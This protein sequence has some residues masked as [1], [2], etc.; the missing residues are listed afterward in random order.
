VLTAVPL[1]LAVT[2]PV[3]WGGGFSPPAQSLFVLLAGGAVLAAARSD[4]LAAGAAARSPLALVL[5]AL[6]GLSAASAAW[7]IASPGVALR[8]GLVVAGYAGIVIAGR[9]TAS[10]LGATSIAVAVAAIAATEAVLG[11]AAVATHALP[12]AE[13]LGRVWRPGG[14]FEY[15][16]ALALLQVG[17]LSVLA[18]AIRRSSAVAAGVAAG[19]TTLAG[20]VLALSG[21]RLA[22]ALAAIV[23]VGLAWDRPG[24]PG[25]RAAA[26]AVAILAT[27]G[28]ILASVLLGGAVGPRSPAPGVSGLAAFAAVVL[29]GALT[30]PPARDA[31]R[32]RSHAPLAVTLGCAAAVLAAVALVGDYRPIDLGHG[33]RRAVG[34]PAPREQ[35]DLVHER[36]HEWL[37]AIQTWIDRPVLGAG[38]GAYYPA[39]LPHQRVARSL[40]AH[41]LPLELAA[42]LGIAG[43]LLGIGLYGVCARALWR[44]R[45]DADWWLLAPLVVAFLVSNM[46]DWTWHLSGLTALW[47]AAAGGLI[48]CSPIRA[49]GA[50]TRGRC[51]G[52]GSQPP[53]P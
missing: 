9:A 13:R 29:A 22:L 31:W 26:V 14:T 23:V 40:Y 36:T 52:I 37:A 24:E 42:E 30:L 33:A 3:F 21:S 20:A 8:S 4:R 38:A 46:I 15:Q 43:L 5:I 25:A 16:P 10:T 2:V 49:P 39:S 1:A 7:T 19:A 28:G 51:R 27:V 41:D 35:T 34:A 44:V 45:A 18:R 53:G 48:G 50:P 32:R 12:D 17:A 47:A 11:L 6:A